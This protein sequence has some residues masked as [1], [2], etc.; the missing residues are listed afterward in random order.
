MK[1]NMTKFMTVGLVLSGL[2][3]SQANSVLPDSYDDVKRKQKCYDRYMPKIESC[4]EEIADLKKLDPQTSQIKALIN[5]KSQ[6][7]KKLK[8]AY[9][10]CPEIGDLEDVFP[11]YR[12]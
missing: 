11:D 7:L 5:K 6:K 4:E 10:K 8:E 12:M 3:M 2:F 9:K 1:K